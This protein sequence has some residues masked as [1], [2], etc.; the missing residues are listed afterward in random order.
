MFEKHTSVETRLEQ[1][2]LLR[3]D[4]LSE[5]DIVQKFGEIKVLPRYIDYWTPKE[6]PNPFEI[7]ENGYFCTT[8]ISILMYHVLGH[9]GFINPVNTNW[10]VISNNIN[11]KDGAVFVHN[12]KIY[13]LDQS[14]P[15]NISDAEDHYI[16]LIDHK[17]LF[18]PLI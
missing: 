14:Q 13:N 17:N 8:G 9:L 18:L 2:R 16:T 4:N 7:I 10:K 5:T 15:L 1:Y 12:N 3:T 6:W 11:G